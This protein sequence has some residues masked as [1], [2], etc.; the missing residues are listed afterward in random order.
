MC[1]IQNR[2]IFFYTYNGYLTLIKQYWFC[3]S[4]NALFSRVILLCLINRKTHVAHLLFDQAGIYPPKDCII[5][6]TLSYQLY[7]NTYTFYA[8]TELNMV[9]PTILKHCLPLRTTDE[10]CK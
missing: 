10:L 8:Q 6:S 9:M 1:I 7:L 2:V 3:I 5:N 4:R